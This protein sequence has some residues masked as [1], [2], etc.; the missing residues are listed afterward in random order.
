MVT[1]SWGY[2][3]TVSI[4]DNCFCFTAYCVGDEMKKEPS[5]QIADYYIKE[6]LN[7][8]K[9]K[10]IEDICQTLRK[11]D[12]DDLRWGL[13]GNTFEELTEILETLPKIKGVK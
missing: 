6:L 4:D 12:L 3:R 11:Q 1:N 2:L 7:P 10:R 9:R 13:Y 8:V 5:L